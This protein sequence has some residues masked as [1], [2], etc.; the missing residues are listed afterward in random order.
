MSPYHRT[1][2]IELGLP[3]AWFE[4]EAS[5]GSVRGWFV[6]PEVVLIIN[7]AIALKKERAKG[8][9]VYAFRVLLALVAVVV[10]VVASVAVVA[11]VTK[12]VGRE[13]A[14]EGLSSAVCT[15]AVSVTDVTRFEE[16]TGELG[17]AK[18]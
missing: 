10:V 6:G 16:T 5:E 13:V 8:A 15:T 7:T 17:D 3:A 1:R 4:I 9:F 2:R 12:F 18:A 11:D 14:E